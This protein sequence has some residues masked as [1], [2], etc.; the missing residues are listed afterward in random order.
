MS[1]PVH[2]ISCIIAFINAVWCVH[3][4]SCCCCCMM[5][6]CWVFFTSVRHHTI[7]LLLSLTRYI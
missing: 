3:S 5:T 1:F 4:V 7:Q 2:I 6:C